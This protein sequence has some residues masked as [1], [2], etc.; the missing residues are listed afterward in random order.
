[1]QINK[2]QFL[3][4]YLKHL[5]IWM[6]VLSTTTLY[7]QTADEFYQKAM[8]YKANDN[9]TEA[10]RH[11]EKAIA[12]NP[13]NESY[14]HELADIQYYRRAYYLAI[15]M[16]E[17]MLAQDEDNI[18]YLTR[19]AEMYS[20]S[21]QKMKGVAYAD[22]VMKKK[23]SDAEILMKLARTYSEVEHYKKAVDIYEAAYKL[24]P[25]DKELP[26]RI[27]DC[28]KRMNNYRAAVGYYKKAFDLDPSSSQKSYDAAVVCYNANQFSDAVNLFQVAEKNGYNVSKSFYQNYANAYWSMKDYDNSIAM[29]KKAIELAPFD[30]NLNLDFADTYIDAQRYKQSRDLLDELLAQYPDDPEVLYTMGMSYYKE[31]NTGKAERYFE[32][33]FKIDPSL[34]ALRYQKMTFQ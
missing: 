3:N 22:K 7:A 26:S 16:Y 14:E 30:K 13:L 11:L 24:N 5:M 18:I 27:G 8:K 25:N 17:K 29:Y 10:G 1:M 32:K 4:S 15:P 23:P 34:K 6:S 12:A 33:A 21:A 9:Y 19:L 20:M 31:G 28:Y 2:K